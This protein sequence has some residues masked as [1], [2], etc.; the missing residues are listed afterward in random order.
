MAV[1][2]LNMQQYYNKNV[3]LMYEYAE[4]YDKATPLVSL[5]AL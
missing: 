1:F 4:N 2:W 5:C 3:C